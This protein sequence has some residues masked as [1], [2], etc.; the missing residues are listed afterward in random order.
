MSDHLVWVHEEALR[1]NHPVF[2]HTN[3]SADAVFVWDDEHLKQMGYSFQRLIF[4][5]ETLCELDVPVY[6]GRT[7]LL[8]PQLARQF[9]KRVIRVADSPN[10]ALI[11]L[12]EQLGERVPIDCIEEP[13]FVVPDRTPDLRRFSRYWRRV[14]KPL[15]RP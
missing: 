1:L 14:R 13:A 8:L 15:L 7:T 10:P 5:F 6:R 12:R 9:G 11:A 2:D 4:I 3:G